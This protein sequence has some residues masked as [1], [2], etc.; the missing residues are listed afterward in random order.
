MDPNIV[1]SPQFGQLFKVRAKEQIPFLQALQ[2]F[3]ALMTYS[4]VVSGRSNVVEDL[5]RTNQIVSFERN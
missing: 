2:M 1:G 4:T 3:C 5:K